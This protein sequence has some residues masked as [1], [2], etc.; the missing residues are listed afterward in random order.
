MSLAGQSFHTTCRAWR[1]LEGLPRHIRGR[2]LDT[3]R[4]QCALASGS[5]ANALSGRRQARLGGLWTRNSLSPCWAAWPD[6]SLLPPKH[7][8]AK[9]NACTN[10]CRRVDGWPNPP[11][12]SRRPR[13]PG[14]GQS[15]PRRRCGGTAAGVPGRA[16][17]RPARQPS[18]RGGCTDRCRPGAVGAIGPRRQPADDLVGHPVPVGQPHDPAQRPANRARIVNGRRLSPRRLKAA[19]P[20]SAQATRRSTGS[21]TAAPAA[22]SPPPPGHT[23]RSSPLPAA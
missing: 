7:P 10:R 5:A 6:T 2:S 11:A 13:G 18:G 17:S 4:T 3:N 1:W 20:G 21:G 9:S 14:S 23:A 15:S 12:R 22:P 8:K 19:A 16:A